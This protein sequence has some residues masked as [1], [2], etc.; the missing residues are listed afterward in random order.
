[1]SA[2]KSA[3]ER[4]LERE[5]R[6]LGVKPPMNA[7]PRCFADVPPDAPRG[8]CPRCLL[9][10]SFGEPEVVVTRRGEPAREPPSIEAIGAHFP[11]LEIVRLVG[12]GG[13]G[14]VYE[15]RQKG[16]GRS[17]ALKILDADLAEDP[18]FE[19]RFAREAL[20]LARLSHPNIVAVHDCGRAGPHFFLV[21]EFVDGPNLREA[22]RS[23]S[24]APAQALVIVAQIC[25]ALEF[26]H[27]SGVVHRD[28]KPENVL[29]ARDGTV[30]IADFGLAKLLD[31]PAR[32][33]RFVTRATQAVG[34]PHYMAP[35]QIEK[36]LSVDHRADI[37]SLGVVLYELLTG[38]L[39][40]GRFPLPSQK[41]RIDVRIDDIVVRT[42]EK[43][44]ERRYQAAHEVRTAVQDFASRAD[45]L[46]TAASAPSH[47]LP[48][49]E[50]TSSRGPKR[51]VLIALLA[52]GVLLLGLGAAAGSMLLMSRAAA[53][54]RAEAIATAALARER[55]LALESEARS[56]AEAAGTE[57]TATDAASGEADV[58]APPQ[59]SITSDPTLPWLRPRFVP[60]SLSDAAK[61]ALATLKS[62]ALARYESELAQRAARHGD[63]AAG[64]LASLRIGEFK[65]IRAQLLAD[66]H[67]EL[68]ALLHPLDA[69]ALELDGFAESLMPLGLEDVHVRIRREGEHVKIDVRSVA[70]DQ[71]RFSIL[72]L[73]PEVPKPYD[74]LVRRQA[75]LDATPR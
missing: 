35:E 67:G 72:D 60:R 51:V 22:L 27:K 39:P 8:L 9:S 64:D 2:T 28:I 68:R 65:A 48:R 55:A 50:T 53:R 44:P 42:L 63:L 15:A 10:V 75:E 26:A 45:R 43:E 54:E 11:Q 34:T 47:A 30:K 33:G 24:I 41:V 3:R 71:Q 4:N 56:A 16:L 19:E 5:T 25:S 13:M 38:E 12:R 20:A 59:P 14:A 49:P 36:P 18:D 58:A 17:V 73:R 52:A 32:D 74:S 62:A 7:C 46:G 61:E 29:L 69:D 37:Y 70:T 6:D 21:M 66:V 31:A 1:M 57:P 23:T 40:L